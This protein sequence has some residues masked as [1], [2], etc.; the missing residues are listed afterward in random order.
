MSSSRINAFKQL[1]EVN[2]KKRCY[3][4]VCVQGVV[5]K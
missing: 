1:D 5:G 3:V 4:V 2:K